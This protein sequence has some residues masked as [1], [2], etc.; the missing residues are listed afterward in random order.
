MCMGYHPRIESKDKASFVTT[1]T[2]NSELW[3]ANNSPVEEFTLGLLAKLLDRYKIKLYAFALE[4]SHYHL[5]AHFP[6]E[7]RADLTR[8]FNSGIARAVDRLTP[9]FPGGKFWGRRYSAEMIASDKDIERQF[10]YT[11]LQPVSDGLVPRISEYPFYNC[12]HDAVC[13]IKRKHKSVNW[14]KYNAA[15][16]HNPNLHPKDFTEIYYLSYERLPGYEEL[17]PHEYRVLMEKKL[18]EHRQEIIRKRESEGKFT[19][20]G[21]EALLKTIP[22]T[23]AKNPKR[24]TIRSHR[25]RVLSSSNERR[26]IAKMWYFSI[27]FKYKKASLRYRAGELDVE[28]PPGTYRPPS[29]QV[30]R[31]SGLYCPI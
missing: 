30:V 26:A 21:T 11:V 5:P 16:R 31:P 6:L 10:F 13:G 9:N 18:E 27:Y 23:P 28:F 14:G 8:D 7:N 19:F 4:G 29:W 15:K 20:L 12:F 2:R 17:S 22:G 25:P 3:L 1:R 24:S